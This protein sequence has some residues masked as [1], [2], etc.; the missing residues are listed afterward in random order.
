MA[1]VLLTGCDISKTTKIPI[2]ILTALTQSVAAM[3][4]RTQIRTNGRKVHEEGEG[5]DPEIPSVDYIT[6][7]EL[8]EAPTL[9]LVERMQYRTRN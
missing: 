1:Q 8:E 4:R 3:L 7:M 2:P 5:D 6:T 9:A